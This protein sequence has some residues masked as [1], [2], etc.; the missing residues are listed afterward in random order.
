MTGSRPPRPTVAPRG[1]VPDRIQELERLVVTLM[2]QVG[3]KKYPAPTCVPDTPSSSG[4]DVFGQ[5][6]PTRAAHSPPSTTN[7]EDA[8]PSPA[9][10][11]LGRIS[12]NG[13]CYV[14]SAH[15]AAVLDSI[16]ELRDHFEK[17]ELRAQEAPVPEPV[18][19]LDSEPLLLYGCPEMATEAEIIA[20]VPPR[21]VVDRL[22]SRFFNAGD[23]ASGKYA[24]PPESGCVLL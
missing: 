1:N 22:V 10:S 3:R 2:Q 9:P 15:W 4:A 8:S 6:Y 14:G 11:E 18:K 21:P 7:A 23:M 24:G 20:S 17:E 16:A 12:P 19:R 13:V 5:W